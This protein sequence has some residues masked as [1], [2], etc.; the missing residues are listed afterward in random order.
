MDELEGVVFPCSSTPCCH[1]CMGH[2][3]CCAMFYQVYIINSR[4]LFEEPSWSGL[5]IITCP[6]VSYSSHL[7]LSHR[8]EVNAEER[9]G[10]YTYCICVTHNTDPF[11]RPGTAQHCAQT[12]ST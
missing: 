5:G 11:D 3:V 7:R 12:R 4:V 10:R 6:A 1:V 2:L 8:T 9:E